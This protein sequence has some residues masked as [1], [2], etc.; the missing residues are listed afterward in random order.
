[1]RIIIATLSNNLTQ[2]TWLLIN[3]A[4]PNEV[5]DDARVTPLHYAACY[6]HYD[7]A[8]LLLTAGA[9]IKK[10]RIFRENP[11]QVAFAHNQHQLVEL[12][13]RV[14]YGGEKYSH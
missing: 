3:G 6:G 14:S 10:D 4:D 8:I 12:F 13:T 2:L 5:E 1:M 11:I 9:K 7:A